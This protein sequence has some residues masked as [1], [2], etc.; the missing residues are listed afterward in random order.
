MTLDRGGFGR[1]WTCISVKSVCRLIV[2]SWVL[3]IVAWNLQ[4]RS[5]LPHT[6]GRSSALKTMHAAYSFEQC[7]EPLSKKPLQGFQGPALELKQF[8]RGS[9]FSGYSQQK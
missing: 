4:F 2:Q 6:Y 5:S 7:K 3:I 8:V 9:R 1:F